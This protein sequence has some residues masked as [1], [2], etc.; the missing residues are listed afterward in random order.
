MPSISQTLTDRYNAFIAKARPWDFFM[1][2]ADYLEYVLTTP[3][4]KKVVDEQVAARDAE[5]QEIAR[6]EEQS[7]Q[8]FLEAWQR[9]TSIATKHKL[10]VGTFTAF[11]SAIPTP[12]GQKMETIPEQMKAF[13]DGRLGMSGFRSDHL[14]RFVFD[15]ATNLLKLGYENELGEY[16]V[17]VPEA[18][19]Y[20][21]RVNG[22]NESGLVYGGNEHGNFIFSK[23]WPER[24]AK[25]RQVERARNHKTWGAFDEVLKFWQGRQEFLKGAGFFEAMQDVASTE[26]RFGGKDAL[27]V[28][29]A[30]KD[31]GLMEENHDVAPSALHFLRL[32]DF[33]TRVPT[34]AGV[35]YNSLPENNT[36]EAKTRRAAVNKAFQKV[37]D[38]AWRDRVDA[39]MER[40][41]A[42]LEQYELDQAERQTEEDATG[43][44]WSTGSSPT[45]D[46][47]QKQILLDGRTCQIPVTAVNQTVLC[48]ALFSQPLGEWVTEEQV[49]TLF[50]RG[51]RGRHDM[52]NRK[53][54]Y[55][56]ARA[57]N[58]TVLKQFGIGRFLQ[59]QPIRRVRV[60]KEIFTENSDSLRADSDS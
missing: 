19:T 58:A 42:F 17:T 27:D 30:A 46:F 10:D 20:F 59:Y 13:E 53:S 25:V 57:I 32:E 50:W 36:P 33:R 5:Y 60:R 37:R 14:E 29:W 18:A 16:L 31:L 35:L 9:L 28:A 44:W 41:E 11:T 23:T 21:A 4:L 12:P 54:F 48:E 15:M 43:R 40:M 6:L 2:L 38:E 3:S 47:D 51:T 26:Y 22:P 55:D 34:V 1:G 49:I 8:E 45:Y 52:E 24:F 39:H 7:S 56:A